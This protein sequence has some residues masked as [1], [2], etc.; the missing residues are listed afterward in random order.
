IPKGGD[1]AVPGPDLDWDRFLGD[2]PKA[3]FSVS[4][5]FQWRLYWDYAGG[6]STDLLVHTFTPVH[7][8]LELGYPE[9]VFGGGGMFQYGGTREVPDQCNMI[10]DY[11]GGPSVVL[12]N[13]LS[14]ATPM[15]YPNGGHV[16]YD[17]I[18]RGTEGIIT[19]E[20]QGIVILPHGAKTPTHTIP[21]NGMGNT[22]LLWTDLLDCVR[23]RKQPLSPVSIAA[24]VQAPLSMAILSH[25]EGKVAKFDLEKEDIVL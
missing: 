20:K 23:S 3:P 7:R 4:R 19:F 8:V 25:R 17:T 24:K 9:R 12:T 13:S 22:S 16:V 18:I 14:N 10:I 5:F 6:P 2:A 21:W 15:R 11:P 1:K